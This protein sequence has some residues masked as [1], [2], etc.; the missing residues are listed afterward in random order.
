[1]IAISLF[2]IFIVAGV[3]ALRRYKTY[4]FEDALATPADDEVS[5]AW[6]TEVLAR[7]QATAAAAEPGST[8]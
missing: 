5:P 4:L 1:M 3:I 2:L 6:L 7:H 8:V